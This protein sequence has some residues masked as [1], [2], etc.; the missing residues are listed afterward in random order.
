MKQPNRNPW[1]MPVGW[2]ERRHEKKMRRVDRRREWRNAEKI[3]NAAAHWGVKEADS[4][5]NKKALGPLVGIRSIPVNS[6]QF[7][8]RARGLISQ[9]PVNSGQFRSRAR[10][11]ISQNPVNSGQFRSIPVNSGHEIDRSHVRQ[12]VDWQPVMGAICYGLV[13]RPGHFADQLVMA[14]SFHQSIPLSEGLLP[15]L[16]DS[17]GGRRDR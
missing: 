4:E 1:M 15:R 13:S 14:W 16:A 12:D 10:G 11:P 17:A 9:N 8:S 3:K 6:G 2:I 7:R 5:K